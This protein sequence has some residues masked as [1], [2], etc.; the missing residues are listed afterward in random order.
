MPGGEVRDGKEGTEEDEHTDIGHTDYIIRMIQSS[1]GLY[2][3]EV[4]LEGE[5][6]V[7]L[8]EEIFPNNESAIPAGEV[9]VEQVEN[10]ES[11]LGPMVLTNYIAI[12]PSIPTY[13]TGIIIIGLDMPY[14]N[15][16]SC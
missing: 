4:N 15:N 14:H 10:G 6:F 5:S 3:Y 16:K 8:S 2:P 12:V 1:S 13:G 11:E 7:Y 9:R